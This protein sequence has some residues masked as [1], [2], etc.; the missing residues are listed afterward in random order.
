MNVK[1]TIFF[2]LFFETQNVISIPY[3]SLEVQQRKIKIN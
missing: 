1:R 3:V 2:K